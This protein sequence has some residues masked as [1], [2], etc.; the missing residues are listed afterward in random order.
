MWA[1][2]TGWFRPSVQRFPDEFEPEQDSDP[3]VDAFGFNEQG[4]TGPTAEIDLAALGVTHVDGV[5][6]TTAFAPATPYKI[7]DVV[8]VGAR[9]YQCVPAFNT[10]TVAS[11]APSDDEV[12]AARR[13]RERSENMHKQPCRA[14]IDARIEDLEQQLAIERARRVALQQD[15]ESAERER[16]VYRVGDGHTRGVLAP[17]LPPRLR[18]VRTENLA[19]HVVSELLK[20]R[21]AKRS[22]RGKPSRRKARTR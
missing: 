11:F 3:D 10:T 5:P 13:M 7:G 17:V 1:W 21:D 14:A 19:E 12:E 22:N 15:F 9:T 4:T 18:N 16:A 2:L 6:T 20:L 8:N